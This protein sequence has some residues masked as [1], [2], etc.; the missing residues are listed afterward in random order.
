MRACRFALLTILLMPAFAWAADDVLPAEAGIPVVDWK[1]AANHMDQEVIVQGRIVQARNIG[2][3]CFLNFDG[4][5]TFTA[6]VHSPNYKNFPTPPEQLYGGKIVRI[7][8]VISAYRGKPQ[9]EVSRAEQ[10]TILEKELPIEPAAEKK[11]HAFNGT[12]TVATFNVLNL[13]DDHDDPYHAD[14]GTP[15]KPKAELERLAATIRAL[16]ADV[17]ALQEIENRGYLE[18]FNAAL[19]SDLGYE[20]V[21]CFDSNDRRGIDCAVLSRLPVGPVTSWRHLRFSDGSGGEMSYNR[22]LLQV[23]IEPP[24]CP[25]FDLFVVHFKSKRGG[26]TETERYRVA[27]CTR[28]REILSGMLKKDADA[29]FLICGDFNDTWDSKP[30]KALMGDGAMALVDFTK[31]LP[32]KASSYNRLNNDSVIDFIFASPAMAK[33][34]E[35]GS[36]KIIPGTVES[37]GSDHNPVVTRFRLR[38]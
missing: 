33:M 7:R 38:K 10:V 9:V 21:V 24:D 22:D 15:A 12:V 32:E 2:K 13:F 6:V 37:A 19:L 26:A 3:I 16:N 29:R 18:R 23:R 14:E 20:H 34:H 28:T 5:R 8:G 17:L 36:Y 27:E 35:P 11:V 4:A 1:D 30:L 25:D 31:E